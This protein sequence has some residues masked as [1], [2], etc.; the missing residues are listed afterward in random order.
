M[1]VVSI[2]IL[3]WAVVPASSVL[4]LVFAYIFYRQI[5]A[6]DPGDEKMQQI[7]AYVREGAYAYLKRQYKVV[8][9]FLLL[10]AGLL[11]LMAFGFNAQHKLVWLGFI[12][13]GFFSGLAG[14]WGM[15]FCGMAPDRENK[16]FCE[17]GI[18]YSCVSDS[19][20]NNYSLLLE[21][22]LSQGALSGAYFIQF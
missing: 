3:W 4:A 20:R 11:A 10:V 22:G 9:I 19:F 15:V 5:M 18:I 7:A 2:P 14:F 6:A 21:I 16:G 12:A 1:A 8:F 13:G 17:I